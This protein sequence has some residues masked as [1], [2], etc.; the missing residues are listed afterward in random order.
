MSTRYVLRVR[1][2]LDGIGIIVCI[3]LLVCFFWYSCLPF[4]RSQERCAP[5]ARTLAVKHQSIIR[6]LQQL[7]IIP[8]SSKPFFLLLYSLF[9]FSLMLLAPIL[10]SKRAGGIPNWDWDA[11]YEMRAPHARTRLYCSINFS[12]ARRGSSYRQPTH[13]IPEQQN[14]TDMSDLSGEKIK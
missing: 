14:V 10:K 12:F 11:Q 2:P 4:V 9:H 5:S 13:K 8:R 3:G 6:W 7:S 1:G